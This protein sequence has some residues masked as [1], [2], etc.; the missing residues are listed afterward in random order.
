MYEVFVHNATIFSPRRRANNS[1]NGGMG[2]IAERLKALRLSGR[3]KTGRAPSQRVVAGVLD[4]PPSTYSYYETSYKEE[5]LPPDV[6]LRLADALET[7]GV[8]RERV[9]ELAR[10]DDPDGG[11][12]LPSEATIRTILKVVLSSERSA[13]DDEDDLQAY[14]RLV[15][16][17]L[18]D[19][20]SGRVAEDRQDL[21]EYGLRRSIE[22]AF[23]AK[24]AQAG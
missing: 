5:W 1:H 21:I 10:F 20:A 22:E 11:L 9:L 13:L 18:D 23:R 12:K 14:G 17:A 3:T 19:V 24:Y 7:F 15:R 16:T 6:A 2:R 8:S 4:M